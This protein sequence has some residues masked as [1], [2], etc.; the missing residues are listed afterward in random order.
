[1]EG[2]GESKGKKK[3][4][5]FSRKKTAK[6]VKKQEGEWGSERGQLPA[7]CWHSCVPEGTKNKRALLN[8]YLINAPRTRCTGHVM[9]ILPPASCSTCCS[10]L[11]LLL[12]SAILLLLYRAF[13]PAP[14]RLMPSCSCL[15]WADGRVCGVLLRS[16]VRR[17]RSPVHRRTASPQCTASPLLPT[18]ELRA[19]GSERRARRRTRT[20]CHT[21]RAGCVQAC[22]TQH[23]AHIHSPPTSAHTA[24][25]HTHTQAEL[26]RARSAVIHC[27]IY[28]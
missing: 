16:G 11:L 3:E 6:E 18:S 4:Q 5:G 25:S 14:A 2:G 9:H 19:P 20:Q 7:R 22:V 12:L 15:G 27:D 13:L 8:I 24:R 21:V 1:M 26:A 10:C 23:T 28:N 17:V